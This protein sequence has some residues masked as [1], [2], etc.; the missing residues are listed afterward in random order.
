MVIAKSR[1]NYT[2]SEARTV[3]GSELWVQINHSCMGK[4]AM[5][6]AILLLPPVLRGIWELGNVVERAQMIRSL[7]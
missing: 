6:S 3:N 4:V 2:G 1:A 5:I 7:S